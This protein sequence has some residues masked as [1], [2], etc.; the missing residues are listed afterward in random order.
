M[1][2]FEV[3]QRRTHDDPLTNVG[4]IRA[5]DLEMALL[6]ARETH[7][8][9]GEGAECWVAR[10]EDFHPVPHPETMGGVT[11][12]SYRRQDGY[13]GVGGRHK[14]ITRQ[15]RERGMTIEAPRPKT[16]AARD[17]H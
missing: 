2:I 17:G 15:L 6:L 13:V 11:D 3:F 14:R 10:R 5:P 4:S 7:F 8:R 1:E 12:R 16:G 9:H